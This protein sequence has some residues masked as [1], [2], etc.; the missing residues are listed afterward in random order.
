MWLNFKSLPVIS[1]SFLNA[2]NCI[3]FRLLCVLN[4]VGAKVGVASSA[5]VVV[6]VASFALSSSILSPSFLWLSLY[7]VKALFSVF[8]VQV[9]NF[10][11]VSFVY[12]TLI[13][14]FWS[15]WHRSE[16]LERIFGI[17]KFSQKTKER[18]LFYCNDG[19]VCLFC[20]RIRGH[21]KVLLKL[22]D[23]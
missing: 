12:G 13:E 20:G 6:G 5:S 18:I 7:F 8:Q 17:I 23:I 11:K 15:D 14:I 22:S 10:Q 3:R 4:G 21:Q 9:N 2:G 1:N 19:F 16:N